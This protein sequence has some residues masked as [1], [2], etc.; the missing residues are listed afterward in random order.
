MVQHGRICPAH[1]S[2]IIYTINIVCG[3]TENVPAGKGKILF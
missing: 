1:F 2:G 3:R